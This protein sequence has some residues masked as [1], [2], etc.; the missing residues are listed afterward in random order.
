MYNIPRSM[1]G[2]EP[3]QR[4]SS[5]PRSLPISQRKA[6][7]PH[8]LEIPEILIHILEHIYV[9][10]KGRS[11]LAKLA[12]TCKL[13]SGPALDV[14]WRIQTSLL[15]LIMT[16]PR[17][18]LNFAPS[19]QMAVATFVRVPF[20]RLD[21]GVP[22]DP[23]RQ[24]IDKQPMI[25]HWRRPLLYARRIRSILPERGLTGFGGIA[26]HK[27][28]LQTLIQS[29]PSKP[30]FPNLQELSY[31]TIC[32]IAIVDEATYTKS[33][34]LLSPPSMLQSLSF[35]YPS[36][37][38]AKDTRSFLTQFRNHFRTL[39]SLRVFMGEVLPLPTH[40]KLKGDIRRNPSGGHRVFVRVRIHPD[41]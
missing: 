6:Q 13:F 7:I 17:E 12:R 26:V 38:S 36:G 27:S 3:P 22:T 21:R 1:L 5:T 41:S 8:C 24:T 29:C 40:S 39:E 23:Q 2:P 4:R 37:R 19:D 32:N 15:P 31:P 18:L 34:F 11:A 33:I 9:S 10:H 35:Q 20:A 28:V 14:L 16:L 25:S 30:V